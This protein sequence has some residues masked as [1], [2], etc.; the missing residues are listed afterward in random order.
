MTLSVD[1]R[2][3]PCVMVEEKDILELPWRDAE[4]GLGKWRV[5]EMEVD[6]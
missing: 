2:A 4:K 1:T 6:Y 5:K 3:E